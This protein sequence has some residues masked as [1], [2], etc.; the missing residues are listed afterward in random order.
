MTRETEFDTNEVY[1]TFEEFCELYTLLLKTFPALRLPDTLSLSK[2]KEAKQVG[3]RHQLIHS[4][5]KD[6]MSLQAEI[7]QVIILFL[8]SLH[9]SHWSKLI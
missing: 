8:L 1:R 2:F 3:R 5:L 4:L 7:S 9:F 6:V